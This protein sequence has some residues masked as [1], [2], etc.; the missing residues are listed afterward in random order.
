M[1][2]LQIDQKTNEEITPRRSLTIRK[3]SPVVKKGFG[4]PASTT[5]EFFAYYNE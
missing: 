1:N 4:Q 3:N 5:S 2:C